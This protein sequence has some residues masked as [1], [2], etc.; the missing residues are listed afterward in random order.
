MA[1][2]LKKVFKDKVY[3]MGGDEFIVLLD[4]I[5]SDT[6]NKLIKDFEKE[7]EFFNNQ[8]KIVLQSA[9]GY[10][11]YSNGKTYDDMIKEADKNMYICKRKQKST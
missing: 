10:S 8:N 1:N 9:Y 3:R 11:T 6:I 2:T 7:V 5:D 4:T